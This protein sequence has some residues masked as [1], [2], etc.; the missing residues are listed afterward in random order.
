MLY[1][2]SVWQSV[3][4]G[5]LVQWLAAQ[6]LCQFICIIYSIAE[7]INTLL[8]KNLLAFIVYQ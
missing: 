2:G 8:T 4:S 3:T 6:Y 1:Y 5:V 7:I